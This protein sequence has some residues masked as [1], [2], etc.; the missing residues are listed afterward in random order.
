MK[1]ILASVFAGVLTLGCAAFVGCSDEQSDPANEKTLMN[2]SLNPE[3]EFVLDANDTVVSVNALNEEGNL[4]LSAEV[5][6]GKS[7]EEAVELFVEVSKENGFIVTGNVSAGENELSVSFSGDDEKAKQL[8]ND[9]KAHVETYFSEENITATLT[10]AK[11]IT[12]AELEK[13]VAECAPYMEEAEIRALEYMD[14]VETIYESRKETA[15]FYSQELKNAYYEAKAFAMKEAELETLK[16]H[17]NDLQKISYDF[18][19][20]TYA[21][22][23]ESIENTR[24]ELLVNEDSPYQKALADFRAAKAEY[25]NYRNYVASLEEDEVT[26]LI[27]ETLASYEGLLD[28]AENALLLASESANAALDTAKAQVDVAYEAVVH[29]LDGVSV[30]ANS[31][32]KE[33]SANQKDAAEEF[34]TEFET[35]YAQA[36]ESAKTAWSDMRGTL[37]QGYTE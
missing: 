15:D 29:F 20:S 32:L 30:K 24:L 36:V 18:V 4:I 27:A 1:K 35:G 13:L 14:L 19:H 22:V 8:Y 34:F 11:A 33:I 23:V 5:F 26:T 3:V 9:V 2:V 7:A 25:L 31:Y 17:L 21:S 12:E 37:S 16:S 6:T 10:Q 28:S